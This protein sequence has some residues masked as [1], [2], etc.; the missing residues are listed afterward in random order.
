MALLFAIGTLN[1]CNGGLVSPLMGTGLPL[2]LP[3]GQVFQLSFIALWWR[4]AL[5]PVLG[6][7]IIRALLIVISLLSYNI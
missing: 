4:T 7:L 2:P 1:P 5:S 6:L 3:L